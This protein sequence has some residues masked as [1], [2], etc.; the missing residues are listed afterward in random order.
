MVGDTRL[1]LF[2]LLGQERREPT[3]S[4]F[5][6]VFLITETS[7]SSSDGGRSVCVCVCEF[8]R[9]GTDDYSSR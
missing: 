4:I 1:F 6:V 7:M 3:D 8:L 2:L 9:A 5:A